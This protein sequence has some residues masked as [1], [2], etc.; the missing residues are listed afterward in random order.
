[1]TDN[2]KNVLS[3][4][5]SFETGFAI[6]NNKGP[7]SPKTVIKTGVINLRKYNYDYGIL[8]YHFS[9]A[10][11]DLITENDIGCIGIEKPFMRGKSTYPLFGLAWQAHM[12]GAIH[13]VQR[14]EFTVREVKKFWSGKHNATK[15]EMIDAAV[16]QGYTVKTDHEADA[17]AVLGLTINE[18]QKGKTDDEQ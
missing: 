5:I 14:F 13:E 16:L 10:I 17:L 4:D 6:Y 1:M 7:M 8:A 18:L 11:S 15:E 9:N 2:R 12:L 3:L